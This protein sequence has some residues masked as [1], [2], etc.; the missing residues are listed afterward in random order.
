LDSGGPFVLAYSALTYM[1][2]EYLA[3][4]RKLKKRHEFFSVF[5]GPHPTALPEIVEDEGV[6]AVCIGEGEFAM[7]ELLDA[8]SEGGS[9]ARINN[10][11]VKEN[12]RVYKNPIRPLLRDLD[13]LP[14]P[15]RSLFSDHPLFD[16]E[17]MH[18]L[19]GRWCK[20]RCHFCFNSFYHKIYPEIEHVVIKRS[21]AN[22]IEEIRQFRGRFPLRFIYFSDENLASDIHWLEHFST[23]YKRDVDLPFYCNIRA[24]DATPQAISF[25]KEA[26]CH[27]MSFGIEIADY[28]LRK[29][30]LGK[31][32][33]DSQIMLAAQ[34]IR[35]NGIRLRTTN[36][37][38]IPEIP[39]EKDLET[40]LL[41]RNLRVDYA[42][43]SR[44]TYYPGLPMLQG[45]VGRRRL[46][47]GNKATLQDRH[48]LK[49]LSYL[50]ALSAELP[51]PVFFIKAL[52]VFPLTCVTRLL[53]FIWEG[54]C[55]YF[56]LYPGSSGSFSRGIKRY[57]ALMLIKRV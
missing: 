43:A 22:V 35:K 17:K 21:V 52:I 47:S 24:D 53:F 56:R 49:N 37:I 4:N 13:R 14:F 54:Y 11:W 55:A 39:I 46:T 10:L 51:L 2:N 30:V 6:D 29:D 7:L 9:P 23:Q 20:H 5:G 44:F 19:T 27:T 1:V 48:K 50:F 26:G 12:G 25:L 40:I 34:A 8:L 38:G 57:L 3:V 33:P 18:V 36:M 41:N 45:D 15:D 42:C 28:G 16:R 32:I 31:D